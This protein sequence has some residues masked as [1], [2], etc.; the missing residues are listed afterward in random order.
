MLQ[1]VL[2]LLVAVALLVTAPVRAEFEVG[3][4]IPEFAL[5]T[6]DGER[7]KSGIADGTLAF[8]LG[9]ERQQ[10]PALVIHLLQPDC[11][12]CRA[13]LEALKSLAEEYV[14]R[15]VQFLGIAHRGT[16][17]EAL[18]LVQ[19]LQLPFPVAEGLDSPI[20]QQFAAGDTL[21]IVDAGGI[22][23]FAQ[24]GFG[25]G[26]QRYWRA[27]LDELLAGK[28]VSQSGVERERLKIGDRM[29]VIRLNS[30]RTGK[31]MVLVG[32]NGRLVFRD[33][34]G[35]ERRPQAVLFFFS[36]Y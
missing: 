32:E 18:D 3:K 25:E 20:A 22:V 10:P 30:L 13:Q 6:V 11:L 7:I 5:T 16:P 23:R 35:S 28:P 34:H 19:A 17:A 33:D 4:P 29:P 14:P 12:Q 21:G 31:S 15:G 24:V 9:E 36:R 8:Q 26:D 27:A 1:P 2:P